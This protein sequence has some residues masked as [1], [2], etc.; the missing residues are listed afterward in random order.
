MALEAHTDTAYFSD[1]AG[2]QMFHLLSH[3]EGSG[4]S[5]LLVDGFRA[6][7]ILRTESPKAFDVLTT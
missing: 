5:S 7:S 3:S 2:Y 6:A 4:G 1:P